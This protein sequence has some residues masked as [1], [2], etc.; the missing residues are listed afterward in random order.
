[1]A[2]ATIEYHAPDTVEAAVALLREHGAAAR[3]LAGGTD[4]V[5]ALKYG[6][7]GARHL[8]SLKRLGAL[9]RLEVSADGDLVVG[10]LVTLADLASSPV[11]RARW[12]VVAEA[13]GQAGSPLL[14]NR[15]TVGGNLCLDTRCWYFNQTEA[16]RASR[17]PCW[18]TAGDRC[19][20][21]EGENRC[22]ALFSADTPPAFLVAGARVTLAGATAPPAG[23]TIP[24]EALYTGESLKP[25]ALGESEVV[26]T[27]TVPAPPPRSA[28]VYL[29]HAVRDSLD[30]PVLGVA[31][32]VALAP[33]G[34]IA[35]ARVAVTGAGPAPLRLAE[36]EAA[37]HGRR[38]PAADDAAV[39]RL[40]ART[41]GPLFLSDGVPH[42]R[43]MAGLM[44]AEALA[45]A[46]AAAGEIR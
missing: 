34:T 6:V 28:A 22:V 24:M 16:W 21:N 31:A 7:V 33:D 37:V 19:H 3:I 39:A 30:F 13:A 5:P 12:P 18:K 38:A 11:V 4:V 43:A 36:V 9:R 2:T 23:R 41:L 1:M 44:A 17:P 25:V 20:V 27:V 42:K 8:V 26:T 14:R 15:G 29:K 35:D 10:A 45:R 32:R 40:T 46:A